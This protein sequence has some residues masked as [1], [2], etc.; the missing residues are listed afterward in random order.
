M[1]RFQWVFSIAAA[2]ALG[3]CGGDAAVAIL[4]TLGAGGGEWFIDAAPSTT[5]YQRADCSG[6]ACEIIFSDHFYERSYAETISGNDPAHCNGVHDGTVTD[7]VNISVPQC[8]VGRF[9]SANEALSTNGQVHLYHDFDPRMS[10]GVWVDIRDDGHR[11]VFNG[12]GVIDTGCE[13]TGSSKNN[14]DFTVSR[15]N[16]LA[17]AQGGTPVPVT[18]TTVQALTIQG[19][20]TR[21]FSGEFVGA[22]GLRLTRSGETI[23]LQRRDQIGSCS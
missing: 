1:K 10:E 17:I 18:K 16:F 9:L 12:N 7:A 3:A 4:G 11:F 20:T 21:S 15:S 2:L 13:I 23:E 5:G 8:F 22:S 6:A 19:T 14:L